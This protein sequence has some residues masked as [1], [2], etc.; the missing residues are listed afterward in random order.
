M[1]INN[2]QS[3]TYD[4]VLNKQII[5]PSYSGLFYILRVNGYFSKM[6]YLNKC[7]SLIK[8][9][10]NWSKDFDRQCS[11]RPVATVS[12]VPRQNVHTHTVHRHN[13]L[14]QNICRDKTSGVTKF[15]K[16][17]NVQQPKQKMGRQYIRRHNIRWTKHPWHYTS[18]GTKHLY[19]QKVYIQNVHRGI[20]LRSMIGNI[21]L[22]ISL[23]SVEDK[24]ARIMLSLCRGLAENPIK[25]NHQNTYI[26]NSGP[27][28]LAKQL[29]NLLWH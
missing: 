26:L 1:L 13:V 22:L 11:Y 17:Q 27:L 6:Y 23:W 5:S 20:F 3:C 9:D 21:Y 28:Y 15:P 8:Y 29:T 25:S 7:T 16:G 19:G 2:G 4:L 14:G 12:W 24:S 18:V 10:V